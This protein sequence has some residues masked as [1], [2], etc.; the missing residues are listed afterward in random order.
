MIKQYSVFQRKKVNKLP[1]TPSLQKAR[2]EH[3]RYLESI[4]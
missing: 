2:E 1:L 3:E 4:G